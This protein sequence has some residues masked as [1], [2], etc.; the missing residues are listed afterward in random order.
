MKLKKIKTWINEEPQVIC[1][2]IEGNIDFDDALSMINEVETA[3][4]KLEKSNHIDL[5]I[6]GDNIGVADAL[7]RKKV[8][9]YIGRPFIKKMAVIGVHPFIR[10]IV[11]F[12]VYA[13]KTKKVRLFPNEKAALSWLKR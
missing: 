6:F 8:L 1:Q 11:N 9:N 5:L 13:C 10:A 7:A 4:E 3:A 2:R 12:I